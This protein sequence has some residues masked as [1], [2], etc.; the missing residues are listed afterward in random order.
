MRARQWRTVIPRPPRG[1]GSLKL[2]VSVNPRW[3]SLILRGNNGDT[4]T[5]QWKI[6]AKKSQIYCNEVYL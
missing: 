5:R 2:A 1:L 4:G 6:K 3:T